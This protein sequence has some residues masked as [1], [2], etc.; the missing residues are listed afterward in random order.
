MSLHSRRI[1]YSSLVARMLSGSKI[2]P[3]IWQHS[4]WMKWQ[5]S[6]WTFLMPSS[7]KFL[8][9]YMHE[10]TRIYWHGPSTAAVQTYREGDDTSWRQPSQPVLKTRTPSN[11]GEIQQ[12]WRWV[13]QQARQ[14]TPVVV[15][16]RTGSGV[17]TSWWQRT[18]NILTS[19]YIYYFAC[20]SLN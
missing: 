4:Q 13:D 3:L 6:R 7:S 20:S 8:G 11:G 14:P 12:Q 9:N 17:D 5:R 15:D 16:S 1:L 10:R 18:T 19:T 2:H